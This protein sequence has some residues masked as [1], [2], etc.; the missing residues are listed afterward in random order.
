METAIAD[1]GFVVA[2]A[3]STDIRHTEVRAVYIQQKQILLP[4]TVLV[5][6]AYL[7]GRDAG[8]RIAISWLEG[9]SA[10]RFTLIPLVEQDIVRIAKIL[11]QYEDSRVDFVD[12]SVMAVAERLNIT[13]VLTLDQR[14]F[15][16]FRPQH[17]QSFNLLP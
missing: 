10:S 7:L 17:C 6:V 15:R 9:L 11:K 1:T 2:L 14:D 3:N 5:E 12:A 4:Q 8:I 13:T 16:M